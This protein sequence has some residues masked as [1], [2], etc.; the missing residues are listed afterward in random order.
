MLRLRFLFF[1]PLLVLAALLPGGASAQGAVDA[2]LE[3]PV[4]RDN[5]HS[6]ECIC[7]GVRQFGF[8]PKEFEPSGVPKDVDGDGFFPSETAE[9]LW[10]DHAQ[11]A[12]NYNAIASPTDADFPKISDLIFMA[13]DRYNARCALSYFREDLRRAWVFL[14]AVGAL[15][16]VMS[17]VWVGF[18]YMQ[19][20]ASGVSISRSQLMLIRVL[21]GVV[22]LACSALIW[23]TLGTFL[24]SGFDFWT[25]ERGTF[26]EFR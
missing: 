16:A 7:A 14:V 24:F 17:L 21:M 6:E 25:L 2:F 13:D 11:E 8:F 3:T 19:N 4:C 20:S 26:Y 1:F 23:E 9:G 5:P 15:V 22:I 10:V 18:T 12:D